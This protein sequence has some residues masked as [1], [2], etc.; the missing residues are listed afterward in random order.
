M[1]GHRPKREIHTQRNKKTGLSKDAA[2][3][4]DVFVC[5]KERHFK[6]KRKAFTLRDQ[7]L[8]EK[9]KAYNENPSIQPSEE[10]DAG[11]C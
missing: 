10:R 7:A 11:N 8:D 1:Y 5:K 9:L 3:R 6:K 4:V 2:A